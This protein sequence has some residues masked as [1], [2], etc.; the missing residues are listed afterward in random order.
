MKKSKP[1]YKIAIDV[2]PLNDGNSIRGVGYY[3]SHLVSALQDVC[4]KYPEFA[5]YQIVLLTDKPTETDYSLIHYPFFDPFKLTLPFNRQTPRIITI[6]DLIPR[7]FKK[8]FPVGLKGEIKWQIQ[9]YLAKKSDYIITVSHYSKYIISDLLGYP[10]DHI[11]V[12]HEA[13]DQSFHPIKDKT[14][15]DKISRKYHLPKKFILY[16]GD[17]NWN[18]NIPSLVKICHK[19]DI[20][21]VIVGGA[22]TKKTTI[23]PWTKDITW[24]QNLP[25]N[26]NLIFTGYVPDEDLPIIYNLATIYCQPS[27]AE[28][29]C[30][31]AVQALS[32]GTPVAY[33]Q[34]T[35]LM[36]VMD[37]HGEHFD[38]YSFTS[39]EKAILKLWSNPKLQEK[40]RLEG[41]KYVQRFSFETMAI[42]TLNVYQ[43]LLEY[44]K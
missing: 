21:L 1:I 42:Q 22:A 44:G 32:C 4:Q 41:L 17:I 16:V 36:E 6:H 28:G 8:H 23:H 27:F 7:Q 2:S 37:Y 24:L 29:F 26:D 43:L 30:L 15:L 40:Y 31:P 10:A 5:H 19:L 20:P 12:T 11:Y 18:K 13:A 34:E 33:S 14:L 35:S 39:I 9:K 25:K 38:P 3:T